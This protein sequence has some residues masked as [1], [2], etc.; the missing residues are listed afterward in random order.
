MVFWNKRDYVLDALKI[1]KLVGEGKITRKSWKE[2]II[3]LGISKSRYYYILRRLRILGLIY[4]DED[5]YR[6]SE[7][8]SKN[9][10]RLANY[11]EDL[12]GK[13]EK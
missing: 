12:K 1:L 2:T 9:L 6:L 11:W 4:K 13:L 7:K 10:E 3:Q 8:F 5:V